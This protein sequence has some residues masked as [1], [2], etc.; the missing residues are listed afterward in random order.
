VL[1]QPTALKDAKTAGQM[2]H[3]TGGRHTNCD[4]FFQARTLSQREARVKELEARKKTLQG[5][6]LLEN[7]VMILLQQKGSLVEQNAS[8]FRVDDLK[9]LLKWKKVKPASSRKD[10]LFKAYWDNPPL[11]LRHCGR[12]RRKPSYWS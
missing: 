5:N 12:L 2:F 9:L 8:T 11:F 7:A 6:Q 10:D 1:L 3:A 4:E